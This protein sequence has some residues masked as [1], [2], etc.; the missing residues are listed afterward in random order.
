MDEISSLIWGANFIPFGSLLEDEGKLAQ[1]RGDVERAVVAVLLGQDSRQRGDGV[2]DVD[3]AGGLGLA[4]VDVVLNRDFGLERCASG[5][6]R[7][8]KLE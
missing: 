4:R 1:V 8:E 6:A 3:P 5:M 2:G 7:K